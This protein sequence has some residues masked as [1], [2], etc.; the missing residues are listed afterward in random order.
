MKPDPA[1]TFEIIRQMSLTKEDIMLVG[2]SDVDIATA[3]NAGV[4]P[5]GVTWGFRSR[6]ELIAAGAKTIIDNPNEIVAIAK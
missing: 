3:L 6:E 1:G 5:V 4:K 2:D